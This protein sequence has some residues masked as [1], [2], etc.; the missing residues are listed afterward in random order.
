MLCISLNLG[1]KRGRPK[2]SEMTPKAV[3]EVIGKEKPTSPE[4]G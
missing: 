2:K 3:P 4:R 1:K